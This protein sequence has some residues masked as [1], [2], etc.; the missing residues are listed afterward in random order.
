MNS[1]KIIK[2]KKEFIL[3]ELLKYNH[4]IIKFIEIFKDN[5]IKTT[6]FAT[7][8]EF[9]MFLLKLKP[10]SERKQ[11]IIASSRLPLKFN[12]KDFLD[13]YL[14]DLLA[15]I[16]QTEDKLPQNATLFFREKEKIK[17]IEKPFFL[18]PKQVE[19][20]EDENRA[21]V[22]F[23]KNLEQN[24]R[25]EALKLIQDS[26]FFATKIKINKNDNFTFKQVDFFCETIKEDL[27]NIS[28]IIFTFPIKRN[29]ISKIEQ[30]TQKAVITKDDLIISIFDK[31]SENKSGKIKVAS[32]VIEKEKA[33][34]RNKINGLSRIKGG[35]G[36]KG[37]GETKEEERKRILKIKERNILKAIKKENEKKDNQRKFR[38]KSQIPT[39]AIVGYTNAGKS[40]LFNALLNR[41]EAKQSQKFFSSI[42]PIIRKTNILQKQIL[43]IDTVG[44]IEEMNEASLIALSPSIKE[45]LEADLILHIVDSTDKL[46]KQKKETVNNFLL[47]NGVKFNKI[48]ILFSKKDKYLTTINSKNGHYFSVFS[49]DD[50]FKIKN[51]IIENLK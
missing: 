33:V 13:F 42:D 30:K 26:G 21:L 46:R 5:S 48:K 25:K 49:K 51:L 2:I 6:F 31:R 35:I 11:I 18:L 40:T 12:F 27:I 34:F 32:A 16:S 8:I 43:L 50:I 19:I 38:Q 9:D 24:K 17:T 14:I 39:V 4:K 23:S 47:N 1:K 37:P 36:L 10:S 44:Y 22:V 20:K 15:T 28:T 45:I 41:K 7:K 29:L 3:S